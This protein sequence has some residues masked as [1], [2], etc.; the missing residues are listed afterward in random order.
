MVERV[1]AS[2]LQHLVT[3]KLKFDRYDVVEQL[4]RLKGSLQ[5]TP[6]CPEPHG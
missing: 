1:G 5:A 6:E 3:S 2:R 4:A